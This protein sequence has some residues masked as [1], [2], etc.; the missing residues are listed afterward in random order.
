MLIKRLN[1]LLVSIYAV[2][3]PTDHPA[4]RLYDAVIDTEIDHV[5]RANDPVGSY[6]YCLSCNIQ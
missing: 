1:R 6:A 2:L 4:K 3:S 5:L